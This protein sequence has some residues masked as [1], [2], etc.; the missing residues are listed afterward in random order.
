MSSTNTSSQRQGMAEYAREHPDQVFTTLHRHLGLAWMQEAHRL[1]CKHG[2]VGID[3]VPVADHV[4]DLEVNL[5]DLLG[6]IK[7]GRSYERSCK[8]V[9]RHWT[10]SSCR[11]HYGCRSRTCSSVMER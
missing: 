5:L 11:R 4:K 1:T 10:R 8:P 2:A 6:R 9:P 7:R 3:G